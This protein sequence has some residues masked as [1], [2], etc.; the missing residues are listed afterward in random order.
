MVALAAPGQDS[1]LAR[2][3]GRQA[4]GQYFIT[5][6]EYVSMSI[7]IASEASTSNA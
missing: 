3:I 6:H 1:R 5:T 4:L 7:R 2:A